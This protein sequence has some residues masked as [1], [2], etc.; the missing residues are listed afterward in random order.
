LSSTAD[1][2]PI[3]RSS[4]GGSELEELFNRSDTRPSS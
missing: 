1:R 2:S 4:E 3:R